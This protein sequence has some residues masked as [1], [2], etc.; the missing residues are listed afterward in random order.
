MTAPFRA[1]WVA[2]DGSAL[3]LH[4]PG[5]LTGLHGGTLVLRGTPEHEYE[6]GAWSVAVSTYVLR[7]QGEVRWD[8]REASHASMLPS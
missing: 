6:A 8:L 1:R 3:L 4:S 7:R 5:A 2:A